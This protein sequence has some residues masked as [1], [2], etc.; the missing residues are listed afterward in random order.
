MIEE[1]DLEEEDPNEEEKKAYVPAKLAAM[2][3]QVKKPV[4]RKQGVDTSE[5][6]YGNNQGRVA[7]KNK[8]AGKSK[9]DQQQLKKNG[10][11]LLFGGQRNNR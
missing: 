2:R 10:N 1:A 5:R 11:S 9:N 4:Q 3:N 7:Y 8:V 6:L